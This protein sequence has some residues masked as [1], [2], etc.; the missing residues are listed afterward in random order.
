MKYFKCN[1]L[2]AFSL[3]KKILS[4]EEDVFFIAENLTGLTPYCKECFNRKVRS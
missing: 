4:E 3:C 1:G 2:T